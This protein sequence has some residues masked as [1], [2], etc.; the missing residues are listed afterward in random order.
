[1]ISYEHDPLF[2]GRDWNC[3]S[4]ENTADGADVP[5]AVGATL[6]S[7]TGATTM[8]GA[9]GDGQTAASVDQ[10]CRNDNDNNNREALIPPH[11]VVV[12]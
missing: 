4:S 7:T 8:M 11:P 12:R 9:C 6:S 2:R 1:M 5:S 3:G 10:R